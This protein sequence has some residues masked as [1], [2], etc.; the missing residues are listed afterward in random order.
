VPASRASFSP[1]K[2]IA[3]ESPKDGEV[4]VMPVQGNIYM[5]VADGTN[6]TV[7]VGPEGLVVVNSGSA[8][9]SDKVVAALKQLA[10]AVVAT[11]ATNKCAGADC[12]GTWGWSSPYMN[13]VIGSPAPPKPIRYIINTS[14]APENVG[15]NE[16]LVASAGRGRVSIIAHENVL[17]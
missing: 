11:P 5:V 14:A 8:Q 13:T 3:D 12:A 6:V 16:K 7:S 17:N 1:D 10:A 4:H 9:M 15:G 2:S